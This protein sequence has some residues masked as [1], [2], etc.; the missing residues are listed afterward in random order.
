M[1]ASR[2]GCTFSAKSAWQE[3]GSRNPLKRAIQIEEIMLL[4]TDFKTAGIVKGLQVPLLPG[5]Q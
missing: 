3:S 1:S 2:E 4:Y 5:F